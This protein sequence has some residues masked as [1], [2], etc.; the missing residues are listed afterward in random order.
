GLRA[1]RGE[2]VMFLDADDRLA[3]GAVARLALAAFHRT[4]CVAV[5]GDYDRINAD[6]RRFGSR[7][8]V[9][10]RSKPSGRIVSKLLSGNF[11]V[12]GG[13]LLAR[14]A[15]LLSLGGF[16]NELRFCEDWHLWC[17]LATLG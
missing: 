5:Y 13:V 16:H 14:K 10:R 3:G 2:W 17:R 8:F 9:R 12:N 11:I 4:D 6:G 15:S 1:A 7:R